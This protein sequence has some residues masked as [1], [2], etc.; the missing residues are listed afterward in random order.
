M[1]E[2]K[3]KAVLDLVRSARKQADAIIVVGICPGGFFYDC[4]DR[5][6][7]PDLQGLLEANVRDIC[8]S[9][10]HARARKAKQESVR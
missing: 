4:D 10:S 9:V 5:V 7:L 1:D 3:Q 2:R 8:A 6:T